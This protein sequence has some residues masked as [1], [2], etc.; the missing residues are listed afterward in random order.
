M[1]PIA[2][3]ARIAD[4]W[5]AAGTAAAAHAGGLARTPPVDVQ[6]FAD[7]ARG[8]GVDVTLEVWTEMQHDWQIAAKLLPEGRQAIAHVGDFVDRVLSP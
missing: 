2:R 5:G 8:A 4:L 1:V 3:A 6:R 7:K